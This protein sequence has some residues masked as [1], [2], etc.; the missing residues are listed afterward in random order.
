MNDIINRAAMSLGETA[1]CDRRAMDYAFSHK[2]AN[3]YRFDNRT[4]ISSITRKKYIIEFRVGQNV[5]L[6]DK[7]N[8]NNRIFLQQLKKD[9]AAIVVK[10]VT[11]IFNAPRGAIFIKD[12]EV[13]VSDNIELVM[14]SQALLIVCKEPVSEHYKRVKF[15]YDK[16]KCIYISKVNG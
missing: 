10:S 6:M 2:C 3:S 7:T 1:T 12:D 8:F 14:G 4:G 16:R 11:D 15:K 9:F 13:D 5:L